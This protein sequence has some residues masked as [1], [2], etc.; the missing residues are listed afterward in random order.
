ML[1]TKN[2]SLH[3]GDVRK[4]IAVDVP[5]LHHITNCIVFPAKGKRPHPDEMAGKEHYILFSLLH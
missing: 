3:P 4:L 1:V 5:E 2:P